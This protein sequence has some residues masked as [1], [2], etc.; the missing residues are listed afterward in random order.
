MNIKIIHGR[1]VRDPEFVQGDQDKNDRVKFTVASDRRY[2]D[3]TD[4]HE[5]ILFGKRAGVIQK[6]FHKGSEIVVFGED[7]QNKYTDKNGNKRTSWTVKVD[8]F[9]FCGSKSDGSSAPA[10]KQ[11]EPQSSFEE[12]DEEI[13]F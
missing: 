8:D 13:P 10:P 9:D 3:E 5:C 1:F 11:T 4:F 2:G 7:Q 6:Y 12:I